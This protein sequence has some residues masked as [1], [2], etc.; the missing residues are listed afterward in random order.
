MITKHQ[1]SCKSVMSC[2]KGYL[3]WSDNCGK[4]LL[5]LDE[6]ADIRNNYHHFK[7]CLFYSGEK[8]VTVEK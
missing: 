3:V 5:I 6:V 2:Y 1:H 4:K 7:I 8:S